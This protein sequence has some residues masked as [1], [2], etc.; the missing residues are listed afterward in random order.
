MS[1]LAFCDSASWMPAARLEPFG[2]ISSAYGVERLLDVVERR[3]QRLR[4]LAV[5]A[6]DER[7]AMPLRARVDEADGAGRALAGDLDAADLVAQLERQL[8]RNGGRRR[9]GGELERG[10]GEALPAGRDGVHEAV[11]RAAVRAQYARFEL[12]ALAD[13]GRDAERLALRGR[14]R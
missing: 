7:H 5:L 8:E 2:L 6:G 4:L 14:P 13:A 11:A 10:F 1:T 3:Q 9:A 12:A